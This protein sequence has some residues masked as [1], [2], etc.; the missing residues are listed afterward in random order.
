M[1]YVGDSL[2]LRPESAIEVDLG[3]AGNLDIATT[4]ALM[5][6]DVAV[7]LPGRPIAASEMASAITVSRA[8]ISS[9]RRVSYYHGYGGLA[10][11]ARRDE[12][13]HWL[14]GIVFIGSFA[15]VAGVID[16]P[17]ARVAGDLQRFG[18]IEAVRVRD[19]PAL[20]IADGEAVRAA[21]LFASPMLAAVR[22]NASASVG[23]ASAMDLPSDRVTFD[24][25][26]LPPQQAEVFGRAE[27][28]AMIDRRRLPAGTRPERLL[29]DVM[30]APDGDG[31]HAVVSAFVNE[32]LLGSTIAAIGEATHLDLALPRGLVGATANVR[33][34]V[35]RASAQGDCR[36]EPQGYPAQLLGSSALILT[37]A[38]GEAAAFS[39]LTSQ[40]ALGFNIILPPALPNS[41]PVFWACSPNWPASYRPLLQVSRS[42]I[43]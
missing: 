41:R 27:L 2:T 33:V 17:V 20:L 18:M 39:D 28:S 10:D 38:D 5:P 34:V 11:L 1:R 13:G 4:A 16:P 22:G 21:G 7:L 24:Q 42:I 8:L 29:L 14:R 6:R 12:T 9:G 36:F 23:D 25:L 37:K 26:G 15:D 3:A 35:Q 40:F 43:S 32:R 31:P 19:L 30:V